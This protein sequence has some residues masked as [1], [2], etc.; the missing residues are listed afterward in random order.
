MLKRSIFLSAA[1]VFVTVL[2][3]TSFGVAQTADAASLTNRSVLV[4]SAQP[5]TQGGTYTEGDPRNGAEAGH[6]FGFNVG[7]TGLVRSFQFA[8][9]T[10]PFGACNSITGLNL[11][12][13]TTIAALTGTGWSNFTTADSVTVATYANGGTASNNAIR[14]TDATGDTL[15]SSN[16]LTVKFGGAASNYIVNPTNVGTYFVRVFTFSD[17]A[18]TTLVDDGNVAFAI[19]QDIDITAIV[20]ETLEFSVSALDADAAEGAN[21]DVLAG[22][23]ALALGDATNNLLSFTAAE[24][25]YSY[26]RLSTNSSNGTVVQWAGD[27]LRRGGSGNFIA[28]AGT[29]QLSTPGTEEFGLAIDQNVNS[30]N[31]TGVPEQLTL[32]TN[33]DEGDG[34]IAGSP[35]AEFTFPANQNAT[36]ITIASSSGIVQ[37]ET[38]A[39]R[40]LGNISVNTPAG[41]YTTSIVYIATPTY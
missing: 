30:N 21:C 35:V 16:A 4:T 18:Y 10:T 6:T 2:V 32:S 15:N 3:A 7:T 33:Y 25:G 11:S 13:L 24:D 34:S 41:V 9:C 31:G 12:N 17:A 14:I 22:T 28:F 20:Q 37:C 19:T 5:G 36:P 29:E 39:V 38:H 26:F 40:Y 8:Y 27:S 23:G 1:L